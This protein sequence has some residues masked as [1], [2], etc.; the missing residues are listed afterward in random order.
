MLE[1][2]SVGTPCIASWSSSIPEVGGKVCSYFDPLSAADMRRAV[3]EMLTR[4]RM[5]GARLPAACRTH[6]ARY[7]WDASLACIL[8]GLRPLLEARASH[9]TTD[10]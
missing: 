6:A 4:R 10:N 1:S 9:L 7:S 5:A 3:L 8:D 2:L